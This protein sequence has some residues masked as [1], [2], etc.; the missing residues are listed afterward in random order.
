MFNRAKTNPQ[1]ARDDL[2]VKGRYSGYGSIRS[3]RYLHDATADGL[4]CCILFIRSIAAV[5]GSTKRHAGCRRPVGSEGGWTGSNRLTLNSILSVCPS[6]NALSI[7][8]ANVSE[9]SGRSM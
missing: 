4:R 6:K 1:A 8:S 5:G 2:W 7:V 9:I 3:S